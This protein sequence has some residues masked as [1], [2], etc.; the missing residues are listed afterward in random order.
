MIILAIDIAVI[1]IIAFCC[2]RGYKSG[3][4]RGAFGV[5]ALLVSLLIAN[6]AAKAYSQEFTGM[7]DPFVG[8]I[9]EKALGEITEENI[10]FET[11]ERQEETGDFKTV[12]TVLRQLGLPDVSAVN[13]AEQTIKDDDTSTYLPDLISGKLSSVLAYVA[14]FAIAFILLAIIFTVIGN[15]VG[16]VF[17]LPG[18]A[19][20][21]SITG[22]V[23]GLVKGLIIVFTLSA[24]VRYLGI[25][26]PSLLDET[27]VLGYLV[28]NNPIAAIIGV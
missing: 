16:L 9:V 14:V 24:L 19:I 20:V 13:V 4:I 6:A 28:V 26:A 1:A 17:S 21:D 2:W 11:P 5:A 15:L 10:T 27:K 12:Y 23:L 25:I 18:L 22:A 7:L 3:L 8:G